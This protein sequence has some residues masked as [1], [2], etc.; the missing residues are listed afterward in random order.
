MRPTILYLREHGLPLP[1]AILEQYDVLESDTPETAIS[2]FDGI[3]AGLSPRKSVSGV[4]LG[5]YTMKDGLEKSA[6]NQLGAERSQLVLELDHAL[7]A[8]TR[9]NTSETLD[10]KIRAQYRLSDVNGRYYD[11]LIPTGGLDVLMHIRSFPDS[12]SLPVALFTTLDGDPVV[13]D[14]A[15]KYNAT[16]IGACRE[17]E[18]TGWLQS[19]ITA[20]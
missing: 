17:E 7:A 14:A 9:A 10:V 12:K 3:S 15:R 13:F 1:T 4:I 18:I 5:V 2:D 11:C 8:H 16:V 6:F 20:R 19:H